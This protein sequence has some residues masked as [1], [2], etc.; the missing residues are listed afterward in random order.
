MLSCHAVATAPWLWLAAPLL[1]ALVTGCAPDESAGATASGQVE[2]FSWW[3]AGGEAD[4]LAVITRAYSERFPEVTVINAAV[5]GGAG[6]RARD[7][8]RERMESGE[9]PDTFQS[10]TG[11]ELIRAWV[12]PQGTQDTSANRLEDLSF[13][14]EEEDWERI[15]PPALVDLVRH[16]GGIYGVPVAIH[17]ANGA[18]YNKAL[19][20]EANLKEPRT[21]ED[22]MSVLEAIQ[23]KLD[24]KQ[25]RGTGSA[26]PIALAAK[27][28]WPISML[29]ENLLLAEG[30]AEFFARYF[31]G[32]ETAGAAP[33]RRALE[34]LLALFAYV[35]ADA[36]TLSWEEAADRVAE[37]TS[38][39]TFMGDWARGYLSA[40][41]GRNL[42]AEKDFGTF[43]CP[44][45]TGV[46]VVVGDVFAL[47]KGAPSRT[48]AIELLRLMAS[49]HVQHD[50]AQQKGSTPIRTDI[51]TSSYDEQGR[52]TIAE[53]ARDTLVPSLTHGSAGTPE[54]AAAV[55][56]AMA[57]FFRERS[58][59]RTLARLERE[60]AR[61]K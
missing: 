9:P 19:F 37:G 60:Y 53:F 22:L 54:Y 11:S 2:I 8:L 15:I 24:A 29:F 13:L 26:A 4:A 61:L 3:T 55:N 42:D 57:E 34:R 56:E 18:Y 10:H 47:P 40:E 49:A 58:V 31:A 52:R 20:A 50:F 41:N 39:M 7:K 33:V 48:N 59:E 21:L 6:T 23:A 12:S 44:G 5:E 36:A 45:T 38:A 30:G 14:F 51:D 32:E 1:A 17:K 35:N 25:P 16:D 43:S 27:D 28:P 46:F